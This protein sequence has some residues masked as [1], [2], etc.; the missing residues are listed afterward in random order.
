MIAASSGAL[1]GV[2][3]SARA[4][5]SGGALRLANPFSAIVAAISEAVLQRKSP[6]TA[7]ICNPVH[8]MGLAEGLAR[9]GRTCPRDYSMVCFGVPDNEDTRLYPGNVRLSFIV[10][11][12]EQAGYRAAQEL[13]RRL[14][15]SVAEP[16]GATERIKSTTLIPCDFIDAE[17]CGPV[18]QPEDGPAS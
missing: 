2:G 8:M 10:L 12:V 13:L 14:G 3:T 6:P 4:T 17:S 16:A 5:R 15:A 18:R 9:G 7:F 1:N 11:P